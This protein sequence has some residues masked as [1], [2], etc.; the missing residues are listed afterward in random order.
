MKMKEVNLRLLSRL[1]NGQRYLTDIL[2]KMDE[3]YGPDSTLFYP[4]KNT[5]NNNYEQ[6]EQQQKRH[7]PEYNLNAV[8]VDDVDLDPNFKE[9]YRDWLENTIYSTTDDEDDDELESNPEHTWSIGTPLPD[10]IP[11]PITADDLAREINKL[12]I[13]EL[14]REFIEKQQKLEVKEEETD[15]WDKP[16]IVKNPWGD[17]DFE[18]TGEKEIGFDDD[19]DDPDEVE[20]EV[21]PLEGINWGS[22]TEEELTQR[23]NLVQEKTVQRWLNVDMDDPR[24]LK[25]LNTFEGEI[26]EDDDGWPI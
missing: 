23:L 5:T 16:T 20:L 17:I 4:N 9:G 2:P 7:L 8:M 3:V 6:Q 14:Q 13:E 22:L 24:Y 25:V 19:D 26:L 18:N 12:Y 11:T 15:G 10:I 1:Y 21:N